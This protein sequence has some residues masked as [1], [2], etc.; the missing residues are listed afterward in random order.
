MSLLLPELF[1]VPKNTFR[2]NVYIFT[3]KEDGFCDT[4][5]WI[6]NPIVVA[7]KD[8]DER[9]NSFKI[10]ALSLVYSNLPSNVKINP[11]RYIAFSIDEDISFEKVF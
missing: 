11:V 9:T 6:T 4:I 10:L 5:I 3:L 7:K 1:C 2:R 8:S